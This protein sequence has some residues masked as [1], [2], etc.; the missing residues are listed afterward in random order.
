MEIW[1]PI[2]GYE[3]KYE[4]SN[5][6]R[7]KSL[8]RYDKYNRHIY[9]KILI[10]KKHSGGYLRVGLSRKDYY[11]HRLVAEAFIDNPNNKKY[12]NH[13]DGNKTNNKV[14]NLEW[15][16]ANENMQHAYYVLK[17][18]NREFMSKIA[19]CENHKRAIKNRRKFTEKQ[20]YEIRNSSESEYK[21]A[22]KYNVSR[23]LINSIKNYKV[24]KDV[25]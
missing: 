1:K 14:E 4:V 18:A 9:E 6:G 21:I 24:Y 8:E 5:L 15:C 16:T 22:Q 12:I 20:I 10:P 3:N 23:G 17:Y 25:V 11:I 19:N 7:V 13:I 2:K